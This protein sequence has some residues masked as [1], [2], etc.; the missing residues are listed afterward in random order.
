MCYSTRYEQQS[1]LVCDFRQKMATQE[2][3][4]V[5]EELRRK[6]NNNVSNRSNLYVNNLFIIMLS[7][8]CGQCMFS[9]EDKLVFSIQFNSIQ[10]L[11]HRIVSSA[12]LT[13]LSGCPSRTAYLYAWSAPGST[14]TLEYTSASLDQPQW[15]DGKSQSWT[16]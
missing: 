5:L 11:F 14:V 15:T 12:V 3:R 16:R 8:L 1:L 7:Y 6:N 10:F 9:A 2:T 13:I 4:K